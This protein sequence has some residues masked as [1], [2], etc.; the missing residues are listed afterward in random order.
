MKSRSGLVA[1]ICL[2]ASVL[3][4]SNAG[5]TAEPDVGDIEGAAE[6]NVTANGVEVVR[7][8]SPDRYGTSLAVARELVRLRGG[9]AEA[10]V[11]ASGESWADAAVAGPLA[12]S[13]SAPVLLVPPGGLQT[14]AARPD[15]VEFLRSA[16]TR[17]VVILGS[18]D[19]LPNHEPSVLFGLGMLPRNI[20]RVHSD[21]PVEMSIA[22]A[23]RIGAPTEFAELGRTVIIASDSSVAD[24]VAVGPLAAAGPFPLLL[25][26]PDAL[27]PR[28]TAYLAEH[29]VANVVLVGGTAAIAPAVQEALEAADITVT[30][31]AGGDRADTSR[32]AAELFEQLTSDDLGCASGPARIGLAP[33]QRPKLA[34]TAGPLLGALCAPLRFTDSD[35]LPP[36]VHNDLFLAY[37]RTSGAELHVFESASVLPDDVLDVAVPPVRIA[38]WKLTPG[39]IAGESQATLIVSDGSEQ[40]RSYPETAVTIPTPSGGRPAPTPQWGPRG[41]FLAYR[42]LATHGLFVLDTDNGGIAQARYGDLV[43]EVLEESGLSWSPDGSRLLFSGII[44][45]ES[46]L[47]EYYGVLDPPEFTAEVLL[48]DVRSQDVTRVTHNR[49]TDLPLSWSPDGSRFLYHSH[50]F[51][52]ARG[53][54]FE[55]STTLSVHDLQSGESWTLSHSHLH[56]ARWSPDGNRVMYT[57]QSTDPNPPWTSEICV[58]DADGTSSQRLTPSNCEGQVP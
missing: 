51:V 36:A 25:T 46:T 13:L 27:D 8:W 24:A 3:P 50:G 9:R 57:C 2:A 39:V 38:A 15:L 33:A 41:R 42:D 26:G 58:A 7:L 1:A 32:L 48:Y 35:R 10:V 44:E 20:E 55:Y 31:L 56:G 22:V 28:I 4:I 23:A 6:A 17:R 11:L 37:S 34:L 21:D 45:D 14:S 47:N 54:P 30:R 19:V 52:G 53:E 40:P 43:P 12:A 5:A 18:P 16:G 29:D 49:G